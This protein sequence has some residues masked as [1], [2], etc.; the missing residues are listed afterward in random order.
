MLKYNLGDNKEMIRQILV[1]HFGKNVLLDF[2]A[3]FIQRPGTCTDWI[4]KRYP[5]D[6]R[7]NGKRC[8]VHC[9]RWS[10]V[11]YSLLSPNVAP[12]CSGDVATSTQKK[13]GQVTFVQNLDNGCIFLRQQGYSTSSV[14]WWRYHWK[15]LFV[16]YGTIVEED[17]SCQAWIQNRRWFLLNNNAPAHR[18]VAE[19]QFLGRKQ[20]KVYPNIPLFFRFVPLWL[21]L[22][23]KIKAA[24]QKKVFS[25]H[26]RHTID[27]DISCCLHTQ[28]R[29]LQ[30]LPSLTWS[31]QF[32]Y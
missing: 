18:S 1:T 16:H 21:L 32:I 20:V 26:W 12:E 14:H 6:C 30:V 28:K 25:R 24:S 15:C 9:D 29:P 31:C 22:V 13:E 7:N 5:E 27:Y 10:N 3:C 8:L 17:S 4:R 19:Q 2:T 23:S 11:V